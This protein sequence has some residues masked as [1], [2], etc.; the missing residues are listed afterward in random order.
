MSSTNDA[1]SITSFKLK[2]FNKNCNKKKE[3]IEQNKILMITLKT[4]THY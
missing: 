3:G 4:R 2:L 1:L